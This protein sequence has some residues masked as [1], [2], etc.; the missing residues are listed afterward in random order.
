LTTLRISTTSDSLKERLREPSFR[1]AW[2]RTAL[3]RAVALRLVEYR[4][5]HGLSQTA[6]ARKLQMLQPAI[7]RMETG[8]HN[9]SVETLIRLSQGLGIDIHIDI[10][11]EHVEV[12]LTVWVRT[13]SGAH[14]EGA[15]RDVMESLEPN[16]AVA[17]YSARKL[18]SQR[19]ARGSSDC[20]VSSF[21]TKRV[22]GPSAS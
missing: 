1:Q 18:K 6:L 16:D 10:T 19:A 22:V 5:D 7:A 15:S 21:A 11:P 2:E 17:P 13:A 9:P 12:Q 8:D 4:A 3:A 14:K 20:E